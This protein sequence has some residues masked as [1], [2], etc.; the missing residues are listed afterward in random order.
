LQL[1]EGWDNLIAMAQALLNVGVTKIALNPVQGGTQGDFARE[2]L[3]QEFCRQK[4][5]G[6]ARLQ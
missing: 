5:G 3:L 4:A 1:I 6:S 2:L